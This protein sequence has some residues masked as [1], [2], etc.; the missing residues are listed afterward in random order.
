L[1]WH[2]AIGWYS[3]SEYE[4]SLA[5]YSF[6]LEKQKGGLPNVIDKLRLEEARRKRLETKD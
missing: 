3:L 5:W 2:T 1:T 4:V 6:E